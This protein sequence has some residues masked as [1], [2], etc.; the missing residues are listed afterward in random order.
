MAIYHSGDPASYYALGKQSAKGSVATTWKFLKWL[1]GAGFKNDQEVDAEREG[2]DGQQLAN[3][4]KTLHRV[5]GSIPFNA[6][7]DLAAAIYAYFLGADA[8]SGAEAPYT[9]L[10]TYL[11]QPPWVSFELN[12]ADVLTLQA[13]DGMINQVDLVGTAGKRWGMTANWL[14]LTS[15]K[16]ADQETDTYETDVPF[17]Q[18]NGTYTV[19]GSGNTD[20]TEFA[21][22]MKRKIDDAIQTTAITLADLQSLAIDIDVT[23]K[24]IFTNSGLYEDIVLGGASAIVETLHLGNLT[25]DANY[26]A[27]AA[28]RQLKIEL[29]KLDVLTAN[30][31]SHD[32]E[33]KTLYLSVGA[34]AKK[35]SG[36]ELVSVTVKNADADDLV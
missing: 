3:N 10:L 27:D 14:A 17:K 1:G 16:Q 4:Y 32:P 30:L 35:V 24:V 21:I 34:V 9:H 31:D 33:S 8:K 11:A 23:F 5:A 12:I 20:I 18:Y 25:V 36:N 19:D 29:P 2:G 28:A 13:I 15:N 6:A 26:G 22:S 7:P